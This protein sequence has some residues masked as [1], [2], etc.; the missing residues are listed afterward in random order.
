[1]CEAC[2]DNSESRTGP[3][4]GVGR[5]EGGDEDEEEGEDDGEEV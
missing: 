2:R 1:M 4:G 5:L 3:L